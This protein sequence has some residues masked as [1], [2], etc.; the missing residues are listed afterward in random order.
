MLQ[1]R[2]SLCS[3]NT[4]TQTVP[5]DKLAW[6]TKIHFALMRRDEEENELEIDLTYTSKN[7]YKV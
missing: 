7:D 2:S 6:T 4:L 1:S 5:R 3:V